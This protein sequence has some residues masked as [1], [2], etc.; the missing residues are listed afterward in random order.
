MN[1]TARG[2]VGS[3]QSRGDADGRGFHPSGEFVHFT[4]DS[5]E[6]SIPDRFEKQA[7]EYGRKLAIKTTSQELTYRELNRTAN[8]VAHGILRQLGDGESPVV[9]LLEQGASLI[10][11]ILGAL[12]AGKTYV[13]LDPGYPRS[14]ISY[15]LHD[16][17]A[18]LILTNSRNA[19]LA[20]VLAESGHDTLDV[21]GLEGK[22]STDAPG[23]LIPTDRLAFLLYTSG[24]TG[25]PK[26]VAHSHR[27]LLHEIMNYTNGL[28]IC[29]Q[30]RIV[31]LSSCSFVDS[32]RATYGALLNGAT[33][34]P[35]DIRLEGLTNLATWLSQQEITLARF[36]PTV[37]RHF[38]NELSETSSFPHLRLINL[39]GEP[40]V[41]RDVELS[42]KHF[43]AHCMVVNSLGSTETMTFRWSFISRD[44]PIESANVPV[45]YP[46]ED[47]EV[48]LIDDEGRETAFGG[49]GEI[50]VRSTYLS[51][52][53]WRSPELTRARFLGEP[54]GTGLRTYL[55]RDLGSMSHDGCLVH[56]GRKDFQVKIR[57]FRVELGEVEAVLGQHPGVLDVVAQVRGD[58]HNDNSLVAYVVGPGDRT[59]QIDELRH[60]AQE[61]L[62]DYM[63]PTAF[64]VLDTLPLLPSGKVDRLALP[65]PE[66][67]YW[68][69]GKAHV[70]PR[71]DVE[72]ALAEIWSQTLGIQQV[73][74][75]DNFFDLGGHSLLTLRLLNLINRRFDAELP[76]TALFQAPTI[77]KQATILGQG[78]QVESTSWSPLIPMQSADSRP[79]LFV[80]PGNVGNVFTD[81]GDLAEHLG[82]EQP[83]YGLQDGPWNP[84]RI[85]AVASR[86]LEEIRS[87]QQEGPYLLAGVCSGAVVAYE[88]AQQLW[89]QGDSVPLLAMVEPS[90]PRI[91]GDRTTTRFLSSVIRRLQRRLSYHTRR[92]TQISPAGQ[93][94]Y[95]RLKLKVLA[96][97]WA[98]RRYSPGPYPGRLDVFLTEG[99]LSRSDNR[100]LGWC[101]LAEGRSKV[102]GIPGSHATIVGLHDTPIDAEHMRALAERMNACISQALEDV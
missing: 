68:E 35:F 57:G 91:P 79:A 66:L 92:M 46:V 4:R 72:E 59:V 37:F 64:V 90:P 39:S 13:P 49:I 100:Q 85:K 99:S 7:L 77:E 28:H 32:V 80:V 29:S 102:H 62:P 42:R 36:V 70:A 87:V 5:I 2:P 56:R 71:T 60:L 43:P 96:N 47:M 10:A 95:A 52:G 78:G 65:A 51:P 24:S 98:L 82:P 6:Q 21:D 18:P 73:G 54:E 19:D 23:L 61:K 81:L 17:Q 41:R 63:L 50:A 75:R 93:A 33:L 38:C 101:D 26:G 48:L 40:V 45:G 12:K 1:E 86:Y 31:L 89:S 44:V 14:R 25:Q 76:L 97:S 27:N 84:T 55:T 94:E 53:Y 58:E 88:M 22:V 30:D 20:R 8:Q 15:A 67:G 74:V 69:R 83:F 3:L 11:T 34:Y 16:S 9:V